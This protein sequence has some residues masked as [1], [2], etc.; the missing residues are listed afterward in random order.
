V[1]AEDIR[2]IRQCIETRR[3]VSWKLVEMLM[4]ERRDMIRALH[5][6][7]VAGGGR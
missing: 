4:D 3:P 1:T 7:K 5:E 2:R 6:E